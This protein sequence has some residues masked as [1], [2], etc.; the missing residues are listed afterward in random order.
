MRINPVSRISIQ[1]RWT[2]ANIETSDRS[3]EEKT[4]MNG[5]VIVAFKMLTDVF[6]RCLS[7]TRKS[8]YAEYKSYP[9][10][11]RILGNETYQDSASL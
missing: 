11:C 3:C 2:M 4:I 6:V 8:H 10:M 9:K 5:L 7:L 1:K